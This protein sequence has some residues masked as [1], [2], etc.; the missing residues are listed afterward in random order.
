M[1]DYLPYEEKTEM[2]YDRWIR[3]SLGNERKNF[4]NEMARQAERQILFSEMDDGELE[5]IEDSGAQQAFE[6]MD[7][8]F[9]VLQYTVEVR[10]EL[11][12]DALSQIDER[13]RSIILMAY[14]LDMSD[15]EI[16][17]ATGISRRTVNSIKHSAY[18]KLKKILEAQ[19]Y[20]ANRFFPKSGQ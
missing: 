2:Q 17:D 19:G 7:S 13:A 9:Q 8:G 6:L 15:L 5:A 3:K 16:S 18:S 12:H 10:D 14:W 20:D 1:A 4:S 11:L